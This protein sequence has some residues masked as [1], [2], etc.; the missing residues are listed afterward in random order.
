MTADRRPSFW[1]RAPREPDRV[2]VIDPD[3]TEWTYGQLWRAGNQVANGLVALGLHPQDPV[4][5]VLPNIHQVYEVFPAALQ[6]GLYYVPVNVHLTAP[7]IEYIL[8][9][10]GARAIIANERYADAAA[11][12][13]EAAGIPPERR[14]AIGTIDGF[15]SYDEFRAGASDE[16]PPH[17]APGQRMYYTSGTT[18][19]PKGVRKAFPAGDVDDDAVAFSERLFA[20]AGLQAQEGGV[21]LVAGPAY[22]AAPLGFGLGA[23]HL[24]QTV[25]LMDR[26]TPE[27]TLE[28]IERFRVTNTH[29]V[30]TMFNRLLKLPGAERER[31]DISSLDSVAHAA[32]PCPVETKRKMLDWLGPIISEYYASSEVGGTFIGPEEWLR[33]PGSV[34]RPTPGAEVRI[35]DDEGNDQPTGT[36]GRVYFKIRQPFEYHHDPAKTDAN[37]TGDFATVGDI[38][39]LD[40]DGY[41]FLCDRDSNLVIVG[42]VNVYPAEAENELVD[43]PAVRDVAVIGVPN[44]DTG[45]ELKAIVEPVPG[46]TPGPELADELIAWLQERLA[47]YKCPRSVDFV[48]ALP[49]LDNGKLYKQQLR[50]RYWQSADRKI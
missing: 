47:K 39:Y 2:G 1:E 44:P 16:P 19:R 24:G 49:R 23:L 48:D 13:A 25:V 35:F 3:G 30:P 28:R 42:G 8:T 33:K 6:V 26:W 31:Y 41:L 18:G 36:P 43:H 34:G 15:R 45:E 14:I 46:V 9:D 5:A 10:S 17:R 12:A 20:S 38:G 27:G 40:D 37:R 4:A 21:H 50:D 11:K 29:M 22:H 32:A 7:E